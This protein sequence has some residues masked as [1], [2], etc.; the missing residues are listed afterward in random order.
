MTQYDALLKAVQDS[1]IFKRNRIALETKVL[2]CLLYLAGLSYRGMTLQTGIIPACYRSVHYW[3]QK[4]RD[5]TS[6]LPRKARRLVAMDETKQKVNGKQLFV[7]SAIDVES[8]ELLA[9]Y[10]SYQRS[11]I[12]ALIFVKTVLATCE[13][14]P[15][16]LV[17]GGPWYPWALERYG[18]RWLHITFGERN[19]I[20]R[21]YRTFKERTKRF[22]NNINARVAKIRSLD[23][24]LNLFMLYYNHLRWHQ[25]LRRIPGGELVI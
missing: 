12:N 1:H 8:R 6:S 24:F 9:I 10:A 23:V 17:D 20:E 4:L 15:V 22:Y 2:A 11:S 21:F 13:G 18:L 3:V 19:A 5:I 14:K 7:W 16:V 25:G